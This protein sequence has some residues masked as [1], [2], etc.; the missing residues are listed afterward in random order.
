MRGSIA[1][2]NHRAVDGAGH[3]IDRT[4]YG[5]SPGAVEA[6]RASALIDHYGFFGRLALSYGLPDSNPQR[7]QVLA[8][9]KRVLL[10]LVG[11]CILM[12][13]LFLAGLALLIVALVLRLSGGMK[14]NFIPLVGANTAYL[15]AFAIY[16]AT[17]TLLPIP[18]A[19]LGLAQHW[20]LFT[21]PT[22][23]LV[24]ITMWWAHRRGNSWADVRRAYGWHAGRGWWIKAP[25]GLLGY[26]AGL[27]IVAVGFVITLILVRLSGAMPVHPIVNEVGGSGWRI[28][29]IY[30]LACVWAPV[31]EE[32][33]FRGACLRIFAVAGDGH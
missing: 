29:G 27:P 14:T 21:W 26:I 13:I 9:G 24:P 3:R 17:F 32:S 15:E 18:L 10:V 19:K 8:D 12:A 22:I 5:D 16:L 7:Q 11:W 31:F 20:M 28:L 25:L 4:I 23:V 2:R 33:M 1:S 30:L 6:D